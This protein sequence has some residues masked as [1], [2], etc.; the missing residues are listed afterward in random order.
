MV[1]SARRVLFALL[2]FG[3]SV[4]IASAQTVTVTR[5]VNLRPDPSNE[6]AAIR[7][8]T[9]DE[10]PMELL[11][12]HAQDGYYHVKTSAGEEGYVWSK[13]VRLS[14]TPTPATPGT[15]AAPPP[16][17]TLALGPGTPGSS[18]MVGC[19]DGLWAHVYNPTRLLVRQD[20][21]T[22]TGTIVDATANQS[23]HQPDGV[24]HEGDGDTHGWLKVDSKFATLI[25]AGNASNEE[26]NLVFELVCHY[27]VTQADAKPFCTAFADHTT[28]P[29]VGA[30]VAITG[31]FV[32]EK[33]HQKWN[34][35]HPVSKIVVQ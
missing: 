26:G 8:L 27:K 31:S 9:P 32:Q 6:Y 28:I 33:N 16:P 34:E 15:P 29:P 11:E 13:N 21:L 35:I 22:V 25:N 4:Q 5:N 14:A 24:R 10:P 7:L 23:K 1:I 12:P 30:H 17:T 18:N 20:C 19:G 2:W 3:L